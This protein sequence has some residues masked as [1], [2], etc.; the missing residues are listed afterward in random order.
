MEQTNSKKPRKQRKY[1]FDAPLHHRRKMVSSILSKELRSKYKRR[2]MP[3]R[4]G[5]R[6]RVMV[7]EFQGNLGEVIRVDTEKYK[8]YVDGII[9]KKSDGT[10]VEKAIDP[11]NVMLVDLFL[12]DKERR[13]ILERKIG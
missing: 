8:I 9:I 6:V 12:E 4:K 5:D 7:G 3:V 1:R 13:E 11:S 2:N 10:E